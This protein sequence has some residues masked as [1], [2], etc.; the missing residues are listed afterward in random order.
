MTGSER[1]E[2]ER[3]WVQAR[4][5]CTVD[6]VFETLVAVIKSDIQS[7]NELSGS[8]DCSANDVD[9]RNVTFS[10]IKRVSS[11]STDG[12]TIKVFV[13]H[14]GR[15]LSDFEIRPKWNEED[16]NCDLFIGSKEV[17][18]HCA[19]QKVIGPVLFP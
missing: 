3:K 4:F 1:L 14:D 10:R 15:R 7:F 13:V 18:M 9:D 12:K 16:L 2:R 11:M 8:D 6:S 17:S 5:N 19:S